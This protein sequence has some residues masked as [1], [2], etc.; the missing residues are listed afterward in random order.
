MAS[1]N[2]IFKLSN[3]GGFKAL[4]RYP[5]MLAGNTVWNPWE[6]Q[7]AF[8]ALAT[9]TVPSGGVSSV[10]FSGIPTGYKSLQIRSF[11]GTNATNSD[12]N[13]TFNGDTGS[14]YSAHLLYGTGS[15]AGSYSPPT[16]ASIYWSI[17]NNYA[18]ANT[19]GAAVCDIL[20]YASIT[21]YKTTRSLYGYDNNGTGQMNFSS[22]NWRSFSA[23]STITIAAVSGS[24]LQYSQFALYGVK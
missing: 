4:T 13:V 3:A 11:A 2:H 20:D 19:Y 14:N 10:M 24:I 9:V 15:A 8:D 6:P 21:K 5:D 18:V 16:T 17:G 12:I 22:G 23:I 7:G 1:E